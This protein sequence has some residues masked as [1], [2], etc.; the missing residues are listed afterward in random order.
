[1]T[2]T[3]CSVGDMITTID[4]DTLRGLADRNKDGKVDTTVVSM[5]INWGEA[6]IDSR[7]ASRYATPLYTNAAS[8]SDVVQQMCIDLAKWRLLNGT[9]Q[10]TG[11][12]ENLKDAWEADYKSV[13]TKLDRYATGPITLKNLTPTGVKPVISTGLAGN[14]VEK[15]ATLTRENVGGGVIDTGEA[16]TVDVW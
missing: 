6:E 11:F 8:V 1:M 14:D 16:G 9:L 12:G 2:V 10:L 4:R 3:Y 7:L 15:Q 5:A 13:M